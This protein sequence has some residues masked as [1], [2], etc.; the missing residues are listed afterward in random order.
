MTWLAVRSTR[1]TSAENGATRVI[2]GSHRNPRLVKG[3]GRGDRGFTAPSKPHP[4]QRQLVGPAGT[5][6]VLN[7]PLTARQGAANRYE[8][9]RRLKR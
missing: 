3:R 7:V 6:F 5:V 4:L 9:D 8:P 2:P 1:S